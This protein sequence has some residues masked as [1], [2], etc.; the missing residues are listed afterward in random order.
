[1]KFTAIAKPYRRLVFWASVFLASHSHSFASSLVVG[2]WVPERRS[3]IVTPNQGADLSVSGEPTEVG[4]IEID[5]NLPD[6]ELV[7]DFPDPEGA[8]RAVSAVRLEALDGQLG[9]GLEAPSPAGL[10]RGDMPGRFLW[11][12]GRQESA[13]VR[14]RVKVMVTYRERVEDAPRMLV[15]MP[16]AY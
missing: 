1:M 16:F 10:E 5:N 9:Q 8:D 2:G 11:R 3:L 7:L 14:Y 12:P 15:S 13:T 6:Y 4:T